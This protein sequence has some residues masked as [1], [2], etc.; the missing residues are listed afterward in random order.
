VAEQSWRLAGSTKLFTLV[1]LYQSDKKFGP[2]YRKIE[3]IL[4]A[5]LD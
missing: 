1:V 4:K 3:R 2:P 5:G